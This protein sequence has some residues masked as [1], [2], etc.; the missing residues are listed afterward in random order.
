MRLVAGQYARFVQRR[1]PTTGHLFERRYRAPLVKTDAHLM[2]LIRYIHLNPVR[3]GITPDAAAYAWSSHRA[4]L[5]RLTL[6][7]LTTDLVLSLFG[8]EGDS[9]VRYARFIA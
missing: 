8:L 2:Q 6:P 5:G 1:V 3:A 9:R 4:Y 7:W